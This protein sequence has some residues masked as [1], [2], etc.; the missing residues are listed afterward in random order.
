MRTVIV[1][2]PPRTVNRTEAYVPRYIVKRYIVSPL[3]SVWFKHVYVQEISRALHMYIVTYNFHLPT[4]PSTSGT[5]SQAR[6]KHIDVQA[7]KKIPVNSQQYLEMK[8]KNIPVEEKFFYRF[9]HVYVLY[10]LPYNYGHSTRGVLNHVTHE[11]CQEIIR[12]L[13]ST[14]KIFVLKEQTAKQW[15]EPHKVFGY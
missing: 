5:L 11:D 8:E 13:N 12:Y 10:R 2:N 14:F 15:Q 4:V 7:I 1:S 3:V 6:F 9:V